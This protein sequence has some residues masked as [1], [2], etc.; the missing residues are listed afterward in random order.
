MI[1]T[2]PMYRPHLA[3]DS[4]FLVFNRFWLAQAVIQHHE[5]DRLADPGDRGD[6]MQPAQHK[7]DEFQQ[8]SLHQ[9]VSLIVFLT[10]ASY[11]DKWNSHTERAAAAHDSAAMRQPPRNAAE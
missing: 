3:E 9:R 2:T 5:I 8:I 6:D 7:I 1:E 4:F 11:R 10:K